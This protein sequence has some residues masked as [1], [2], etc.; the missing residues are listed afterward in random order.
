MGSPTLTVP[1]DSWSCHLAALTRSAGRT[2][3][4]DAASLPSPKQ[5][6]PTAD[7]S[8]RAH[9]P[10]LAGGECRHPHVLN[11]SASIVLAPRAGPAGMH[12]AILVGEMGRDAKH[13]PGAATSS[14]KGD[15]DLAAD[16]CAVI[17]RLGPCEHLCIS[18]RTGEEQL[19]A[20][21]PFI[22]QG[23][24]RHEQC[25]YIAGDT[26]TRNVATALEAAGIE[27][28]REQRRGALSVL[29]QHDTY[30]IDGCFDLDRMLAWFE[31]RADTALRAG[32]RALRVFGEMRCLWEPSLRIE[33]LVEYE[34]RLNGVL[35]ERPISALC[36]YDRTVFPTDVIRQVIVAHPSVVVDG[37]I[38][39]NSYYVPSCERLVPEW[40]EREIEWML[41]NLSRLQRA[42]NDLRE[43]ERRFRAL[44]HRLLAV[45]EVERRAIARDLHDD[46]G[47]ILTALKLNLERPTPRGS[48]EPSERLA[49]NVEIVDEA[50][51]HTRRLALDLRPPLLDDL[52]LAEALRWY[53][54]R[55]AEHGTV[56]IRL[57]VD[58][59]DSTR[60]PAA[61]ATACFRLVQ[62]AL[63]NVLRHARAR[64]VRVSVRETSDA[65]EV[66]VEDDGRGF[67][68]QAATE[69]AGAGVSLGLL[70]M[71]ERASLAGGTLT[72]ESGPDRG[73]TVRGRF[74]RGHDTA[75][76]RR[77]IT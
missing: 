62:E 60:I 52:G 63:T 12:S 67:D 25:V 68:P 1:D 43:S 36:G 33:R 47:Q 9:I 58:A 2:G 19:A 69:R 26:S 41:T 71:K 61:L 27:L 35:R 29:T 40:P 74:P 22:Q 76:L 7:G 75:P 72:I 14:P 56:D 57:D 24:M 50:I 55:Q 34:A 8:A 23:L 18:Y 44:S 38:C 64:H 46:L 39:R 70:S 31:E 11:A 42:E 20:T 32:F 4:I 17:A 65:L 10:S 49:R 13:L 73:T 77:T 51:E 15:A 6:D 37:M 66:L 16:L 54:N 45:Q 53:V 48:Q 28:G 3:R 30:L 21:I 5:A 59:L